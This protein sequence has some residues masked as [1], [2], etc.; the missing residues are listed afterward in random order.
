MVAPQRRAASDIKATSTGGTAIL[1]NSS[2]VPTRVPN[3][4]RRDWVLAFFAA[5]RQ[6]RPYG[7]RHA[8]PAALQR[9][10]S[11]VTLFHDNRTVVQAA[12]LGRKCM[13]ATRGA[14]AALALF[15]VAS[16][17]PAMAQDKKF[18]LKL[19]GRAESRSILFDKAGVVALGCNIRDQMIAY[20]VVVDTAYAAKTGSDGVALIR[21]APA[22]NA[23]L[24][25]WQPYMKTPRNQLAKTIA[26]PAAGGRQEVSVDLRPAPGAMTMIH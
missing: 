6:G 11:L 16:A 21:N 24:T 9:S 2:A 5:S 22:G 20:V 19:Y 14:M 17:G 4:F 7:G 15:A 23:A 18:E 3:R 1:A 26:V 10:I 8:K 12:N 13:L 25:V